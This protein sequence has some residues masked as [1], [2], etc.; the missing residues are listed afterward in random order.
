[1]HYSYI[2][3]ALSNQVQHIHGMRPDCAHTSPHEAESH[4]ITSE[5]ETHTSAPPATSHSKADAAHPEAL[6]RYTVQR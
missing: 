3:F 6:R 2:S 4:P 1:M 5:A